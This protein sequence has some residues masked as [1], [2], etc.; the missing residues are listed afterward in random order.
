[1]L[2]IKSLSVGYNNHPVL[3]DLNLEILPGQVLAVVG[4]NGTG[5]TTLIRA[6]SGVLRPRAGQIRFDGRDL[7]HVNFHARAR[8]IAVVPQAQSLPSDFSVYQAVLLGR[9]PHLNWL[10]HTGPR[11]HE[12]VQA[13]LE[14]AS[15]S[16]LAEKQIG[17]LSGGEQ[18]LVLLARALAQETPV[19]LLD[20]PTSHLDIEHQ[21]HI[22]TLVR[23]MALETN[24]AVL[25]IVHDLNLAALYADRIALLSNGRLF[26]IG[27]PSE[28]LTHENLSVVYHVSVAVVTHPIY[29]TP[30]ILPGNLP[31]TQVPSPSKYDLAV[32]SNDGI[33]GARG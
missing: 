28:V 10:G 22:L 19:L 30:L 31:A 16:S 6:I 13:A 26:A 7:S 11:D 1:M 9:T 21:M 29:G 32:I 33:S 15:L 3:D 2:K 12:L 14:Q 20:E 8:F 5:K 18:Q 25:M 24:R 17:Q 4:P 23:K 27:V